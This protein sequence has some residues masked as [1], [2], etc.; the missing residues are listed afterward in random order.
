MGTFWQAKTWPGGRLV[1]RFEICQ[2]HFKKCMQN[3]SLLKERDLCPFYCIYCNLMFM[4]KIF[5][6]RFSPDLHEMC[7][8]RWARHFSPVM[9]AAVTSLD[10]PALGRLLVLVPLLTNGTWAQ[11]FFNISSL[12]LKD[13]PRLSEY[14][15]Y[16][17]I[18]LTAKRVRLKSL[19]SLLL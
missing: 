18:Q 7:L 3:N 16:I 5:W 12:F 14:N 17:I 19:K 9:L 8:G 11:Y 4:M 2:Y 15:I 13:S 1:N 6:R 10:W